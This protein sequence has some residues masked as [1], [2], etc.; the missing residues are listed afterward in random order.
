MLFIVNTE[1]YY[2]LLWCSVL[3]FVFI[4]LGISP[5]PLLYFSIVFRFWPSPNRPPT[6]QPLSFAHSHTDSLQSDHPSWLAGSLW[7][8]PGVGRWT[9]LSPLPRLCMSVVMLML[10]FSVSC[11]CVKN[12][13]VAWYHL[14][15]ISLKKI[16]RVPQIQS[17]NKNIV[18]PG[19]CLLLFIII[20]HPSIEFHYLT[21]NNLHSYTRVIKEFPIYLDLYACF[22]TLGGSWSTR[23]IFVSFKHV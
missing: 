5:T 22:C 4:L 14:C 23:G 18:A 3:W 21:N 13:H 6:T 16:K 1:D 12:I 8:G 19:V 20:F 2:S 11:S 10:V 17:W 9:R 7:S 15:E